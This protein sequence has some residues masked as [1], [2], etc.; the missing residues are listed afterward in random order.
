MVCHR[1]KVLAVVQVV[2]QYC[3][4]LNFRYH[5]FASEKEY[6]ERDH[7]HL[8]IKKKKKRR[9]KETLVWIKS[10]CFFLQFVFWNA[11]CQQTKYSIQQHFWF[12]IRCQFSLIDLFRSQVKKWGQEA[13]VSFIVWSFF[14]FK[15]CTNIFR[16]L[17]SGGSIQD[18]IWCSSAK[19][20]I[21]VLNSSLLADRHASLVC[22]ITTA[23][24]QVPSHVADLGNLSLFL[25]RYAGF[26]SNHIN[27]D[28]IYNLSLTQ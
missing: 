28:I 11:T 26:R 8:Y 1:S 9:R 23:T 2:Y 15:L 16:I 21:I 3:C 25:Y 7:R 10:K 4:W 12:W 19:S 14:V 27:F 17:K 20:I 13:E 5:A 24:I 6:R 22:W 18:L